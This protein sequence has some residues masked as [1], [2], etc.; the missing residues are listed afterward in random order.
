[1]KLFVLLSLILL[2]SCAS[3]DKT[4]LGGA[5]GNLSYELTIDLGII[6]PIGFKIGGTR[7]TDA[8]EVKKS[9][10]IVIE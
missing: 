10:K 4:I 2:T 1:M 3:M 8:P 5:E 7:I 9:G 6:E